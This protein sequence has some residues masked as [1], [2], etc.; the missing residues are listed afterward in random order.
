M[1]VKKKNENLRLCVNYRNFDFIIVKNQY[2][3][4]LIKQLLNR[5]I[6]A[7]I[8]TKLNIRFAYN[9][10]RIRINDKWKI[11]FRCRY[12]YFQYRVMSLKLTNA[13]TNFQLY[14]YSTL[15]EDLKI[16]CLVYLDDILIYL[17]H[18]KIHEKHVRLIF[19]KV[20]KLSNSNSL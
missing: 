19:E 14:I 11:V 16:F 4:S 2:F 20:H 8:F 6:K 13:L 5:L 3:I 17:N 1:F 12:E 7:V 15:H 9:V 18:K 10:L